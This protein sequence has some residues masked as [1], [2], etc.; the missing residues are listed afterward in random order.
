M[1]GKILS[2]IALV[3]LMNKGWK[4]GHGQCEWDSR[5]VTHAALVSRAHRSSLDEDD[6]G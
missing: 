1:S 4:K 5:V 3:H 2:I 6:P